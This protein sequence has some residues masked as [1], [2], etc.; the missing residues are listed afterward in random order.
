MCVAC[1]R[2]EAAGARP[3]KSKEECSCDRIRYHS[4]AFRAGRA[5]GAGPRDSAARN[6]PQH[7][8]RSCRG[9]RCA[10]PVRYRYRG[11]QVRRVFLRVSVEVASRGVARATRVSSRA[12]PSSTTTIKHQRL[13]ARERVPECHD[14][15]LTS[16]PASRTQITVS[17]PRPP[18]T[19][20]PRTGHG[21][22]RSRTL[23]HVRRLKSHNGNKMTS[24]SHF[25][26]LVSTPCIAARRQSAWPLL[27]ASSSRCASMRRDSHS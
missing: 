13:D 9:R 1:A 18:T 17:A 4:F 2:P 26:F 20:R 22:T 19:P 21:A 10:V 24:R 11:L 6:E 7:G 5:A 8:V 25:S 23:S 27:V 3:V 14:V 16:L 15:T 12:E